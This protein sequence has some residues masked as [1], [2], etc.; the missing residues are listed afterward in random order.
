MDKLTIKQ[1]YSERIFQ[2]IANQLGTKFLTNRHVKAWFR[3][4][5]TPSAKFSI[6]QGEYFYKDFGSG[7]S[8]DCISMWQKV[9]TE[10]FNTAIKSI[11]NHFTI[12]DT[13]QPKYTPPP[14]A[15]EPQ[16]VYLSSLEIEQ[17][18]KVGYYPNNNLLQWLSTIVGTNVATETAKRYNVGTSNKTIYGAGATVFWFVDKVGTRYAKI[19]QYSPTD[20]KRNR[21][22]DYP[23]LQPKHQQGKGL[24]PCLFGEHLIQDAPGEQIICIVESEKTA[25]IC[26]IFCP[27]FLWLA[28]GGTNGITPNKVKSLKGRTVYLITDSDTEGRNAYQK[29]SEILSKAGV[30]NK[31]LDLFPERCDKSDFCDYIVTELQKLNTPPQP[32]QPPQTV[33]NN[34]I[35]PT[36]SNNTIPKEISENQAFNA[37]LT[38]LDL[39]VINIKST[40][41]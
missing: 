16:T 38:V 8:H 18:C 32:P 40:I 5:R 24:T 11:I 37:L 25:I 36:A 15:P 31:V 33:Q 3:T 30:Q 26:S 1:Y 23:F 10:D 28:S 17:S 12:G 7:E 35:P 19:V 6:K 21:E 9:Y 34:E 22:S 41:N 29:A 4:E 20:G 13:P 2:H 14:P 39:E 27:S